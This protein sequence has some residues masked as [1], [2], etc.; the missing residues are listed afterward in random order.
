MQFADI[1]GDRLADYCV[2][3]PKTGA[4]RVWLNANPD[5]GFASGWR[6]DD[7]GQIAG[8][9]GRGGDVRFTDIDSDGFDDY[10]FLKPNGGTAIYATS[11]TRT[12][13]TPCTTG[14]A[15]FGGAMP[16]WDHPGIGQRPEETRSTTSM[17]TAGP[18]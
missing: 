4:L 7:I 17:A 11:G 13:R 12:W 10:I 1:N 15:P 14:P 8:G 18:T 16:E 6:F 3:D 9:V 5:S 2:L